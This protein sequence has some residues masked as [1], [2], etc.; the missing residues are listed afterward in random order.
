MNA[1][2]FRC[3]SIPDFIRVCSA[4][5]P[6]ASSPGVS[7]GVHSAP[8]HENSYK[9]RR[10]A[11]T[12]IELL[13]VVAII[14]ILA[15]ILLPV[16]TRAKGKADNITCISHLKQLGIAARLYAEDNNSL[17]PFA[18]LLPS[19]PTD[20]KNPLPRISDALARYVGK[21]VGTNA[22]LSVFKCPRDNNWFFEVEGSSYQWNTLLNG[23]RIDLGEDNHAKAIMVSNG[24]VIWQTNV[25]VTRGVE[26]TPLLVDYD[27]FHPRP[28]KSGKN[29]VFMDGHAALFE[30]PPF[31]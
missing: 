27:D 6:P 22:A 28:P 11:F 13:V 4:G 17:L 5:V 21:T 15:A 24:V 7:P 9:K 2:P 23:R 29:V 31:P 26:A 10:H 20:P 8:A 3:H 14:A 18:E 19:N 12:L 25:N 30:L 16:L 1:I